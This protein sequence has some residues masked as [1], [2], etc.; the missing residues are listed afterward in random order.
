[1]R[2]MVG[3]ESDTSTL[4]APIVSDEARL[5]QLGYKQDLRRRL[6]FWHVIGLAMA[7]IS[8]TLAVLLLT[9]GVFA[10]GGTFAIGANLILG[11]VVVLIALCLAELGAMYPITGGMYS[12]VRQVLPAPLVWIT[13]FNFV[14]QGVIIPASIALGLAQY[15]KA[16]FPVVTVPDQVIAV[17]SVAIAVAIALVTVELG[18]WV[19]GVMVVVE[20]GV[21]LIIT[22]A[23]FLHP[24]QDLINVTFHPVVLDGNSLKVATVAIMLA[25]LAPAFNVINGYDITLAFSEELIGGAKALAKA[26]VLGSVLAAVFIIVPLVGGVIAAPNLAD[27]FKAP[28]P[29]V[30]SVQQSLGSGAGV[31]I[32]IGVCVA[33]FNA[34]LCLFMYFARVLYATGRDGGWGG[35]I[36]RQLA[37][38]NRFKAPG[39]GVIVLAVPTLVLI[40]ASA[41]NWLI[42]FAGT[43]IAAVY[44]CIGLAALW[45]RIANK[46][47][48]RPY[49][50]ILWPLPPIIVVLFTGFALVTQEGQFIL[51]EVVLIA[52]ALIFWAASTYVFKA[53]PGLSKP[54]A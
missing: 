49:R 44:L 34:M 10:I 15:F 40:F 1:M 4:A 28:S 19:T 41:E 50:M 23:A 8:P 5:E 42:I 48:V 7:N 18:A 30:Y 12:L 43:V 13:K 45:S 22:G 3:E 9:A 35:W 53:D 17:I 32:N 51:G 38:L 21:L 25:T 6:H 29:V 16:L 36:D 47:E 46:T 39:V 31:L 2:P 11:V 26:V 14:I 33:L 27:F 20:V 37:T 52:V 24:H 54:R